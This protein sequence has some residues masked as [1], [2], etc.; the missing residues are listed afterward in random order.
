MEADDSILE[1]N[2][3]ELKSKNGI[4]YKF[5]TKEKVYGIILLFAG[6]FAVSYLVMPGSFARSGI[7]LATLSLIY[8]SFINY[9]ST[10]LIL[11][12]CRNNQIKSYY[13]Y[14]T[15]ILG[16]SFGNFIFV[17]FFFNAFL[18]TVVTLTS[19]NELIPDLMRNFTSI[20]FLINPKYCFWVV[21][22]T[23]F[24]T[25]FIYK[26]TDESMLLISIITGLAIVMSLFV[27][28]FTFITK[29]DIVD[30]TPIKYFDVTGSV[31]SFDVSYFSF[32]VQLNIFDLFLMFK[33]NLNT[34]FNKIKKVSLYT[35]FVIFVPYF[36]MGKNSFTNG[37]IK[38]TIGLYCLQK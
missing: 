27:L 15:H 11:N 36:I 22:I 4:E 17:V 25:P 6:A 13:E 2:E 1:N 3:I 35:N 21:F 30:Q 16:K 24:S 10:G 7:I 5:E 14:Y 38:R 12:E 19:L 34:K 20:E 33:G 9:H 8:S 32:I 23:F 18:I 37:L 28:I 29:F 31:F 26:S